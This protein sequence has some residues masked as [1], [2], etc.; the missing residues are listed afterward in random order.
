MDC[1]SRN[2]DHILRCA[3]SRS[4]ALDLDWYEAEREVAHSLSATFVDL[5]AWV[6][7]SDPCPL[8]V[9]RFLVF[10]DTNYLAWPFSWALASR[11]AAALPL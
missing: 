4:S 5:A 9:G 1:L 6:C 10:R 2:P 11:L 8:V 3:V 7:A